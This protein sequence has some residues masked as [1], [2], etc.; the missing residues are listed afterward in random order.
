MTVMKLSKQWH[1]LYLGR[2]NLPNNM[3][4]SLYY[5]P[6][7]VPALTNTKALNIEATISAS[8]V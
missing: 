3:M 7:L 1:R 6:R 4:L 5:F 2:L 8:F